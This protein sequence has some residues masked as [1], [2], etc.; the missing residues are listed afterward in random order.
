MKKYLLF[1]S[2]VSFLL[3]GSC[4]R[5]TIVHREQWES[6]L[7]KIDTLNYSILTLDSTLH[8]FNESSKSARIEQE[9]ATLRIEEKIEQISRDISESQARISEI[10][11]KTG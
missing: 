6:V 8:E 7:Q 2:L 3:M 11:Q 5:V 1:I 9:F 10:S 4:S